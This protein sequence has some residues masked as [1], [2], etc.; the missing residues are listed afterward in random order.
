MFLL[1]IKQPH[2]LH[3]YS[4]VLSTLTFDFF[5]CRMKYFFLTTV[6]VHCGITTF[7]S[8]SEH[9][10]HHCIPLTTVS[11]FL[12]APTWQEW[13]KKRKKR[14][15]AT[16]VKVEKTLNLQGE[17]VIAKWMI[18]FPRVNLVCENLLCNNPDSHVCCTLPIC[19]TY[20]LKVKPNTDPCSVA[21]CCYF[22]NILRKN[23]GDKT[24]FWRQDA[25]C[26]FSMHFLQNTQSHWF[27]YNLICVFVFAKYKRIHL[28]SLKISRD[29]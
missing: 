8:G 7:T 24:L 3:K 10:L 9:F 1:C 11:S 13:K 23:V 12:V 17:K 29:S 26:G 5:Q 20:F 14:K 6:V 28:Y 27:I 18:M 2:S 22:R 21:R 19:Q 4:W 16:F 25:S 15:E